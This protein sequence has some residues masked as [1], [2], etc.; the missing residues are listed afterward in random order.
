VKQT[1]RTALNAVFVAVVHVPSA[2]PRAHENGFTICDSQFPI[3]AASANFND[4]SNR[5]QATLF[6]EY[7]MRIPNAICTSLV[8]WPL[9]LKIDA[10]NGIFLEIF[11]R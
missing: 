3:E 2:H 7:K 10:Q 5:K 11:I 9:K 1:I 8:G 6:L 4:A